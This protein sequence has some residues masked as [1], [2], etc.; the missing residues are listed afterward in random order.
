MITGDHATTAL[1]IARQLDLADDPRVLIGKELETLPDDEL[2]EIV[3][4]VPA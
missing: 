4:Q 2:R 1:A 3:G